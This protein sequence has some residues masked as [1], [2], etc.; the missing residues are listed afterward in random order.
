MSAP[1]SRLTLLL[2]KWPNA[3]FA[4]LFG[5]KRWVVILVRGGKR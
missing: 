4:P 1:L 2:K 5:G 3:Q